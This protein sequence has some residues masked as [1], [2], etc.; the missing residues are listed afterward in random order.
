MANKNKNRKTSAAG[1]N[2][3]LVIQQLVV[4]APRR[5][6]YDV[7]DWR[8]ALQAA[9]NG[10][11]KQLYDLYDDIMI[12]AVLSDAVQKRI[13]A[14][15][16]SE[17]TFQ[18][19]GG[20]EVP[21]I[22]GLIDTTAWETLLAEIAKTRIFGRSGVEFCFA[23]GFSV[24]PIPPKHINLSRQEILI[25]DYDDSGIP[26]SGD[27]HILV[28]GKERDFGL[29]LKA[30]P[31]AIYKRGGFGDWSQWIELFGMPQ[32]VGKYNTYDP[33]SRKLL[34]E[35]FEKAGSAP[36][37][38]IP[39]EAEVETRDTNSG[40]G[41][42]YDEF[43]KANNEE[44]L[45]A[46]LGQTMTTVQGDK[47]AKS[48]GEVHKEVEEGKNRSDLRFVQRVLNQHVLPMLEARGYPVKGGR[49]VF[50]QA[51]E[52]LSV[53]DIVQL[54]GIMDIPQSYLHEKYSIPVPEEGEPVARR[55][56]SPDITF[57]TAGDADGPDR[58]IN[59]SDRGLFRRIRDFFVKAPLDGASLG[60]H[61]ML[62][63]DP[64]SMDDRLINS[65]ASGSSATFSPELFDYIS[66]DLLNAVRSAFRRSMRHADTSYAY[67]LR[68]DAFIT[69]LEMNL[70]HFSAAKTLAEVQALNT[71]FRESSSYADF[72][73]RA[74]EICS[75]F[76][77]A[78][79]RTE[80]ETAVLTAESASNYHRLKSKTR[81]FP[82]WKYVTAGDDR[83]RE[84]HALLDGVILAA[85]DPR[86][87]RIFPPNGWKCRCRVTPLMR[88]EAEGVNLK[89]MQRRVDEY[90]GTAEWE[91][92]RAQGWDSN[93]G[94]SAEIFN[95]NQQYI[96]KFPEKAAKYLG[97]LYYND[98]G[99]DSIGK[100][101]AAATTP[102]PVYAGDPGA[103]FASNN[104]FE[105]YMGRKL[106]LKEKVFKFHTTGSHSHRV[107]LLGCIREVLKDPDEVW[108]NNYGKDGSFNNLNFIKFYDGKVMNVI[109]DVKDGSVY[110]ITTWFEIELNARIKNPSRSSRRIDPRW[111]Y[112]RGL[113]LK[114]S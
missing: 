74:R 9:D 4:K 52:Q 54:S 39:N 51:V 20:G 75:T 48:L 15:T 69:A 81:L 28:L 29:L 62:L 13:D 40:S 17:L 108:L 88:H 30:A 94:E 26:Y 68:D 86:W 10:R 96:R 3:P 59:N 27:D 60:N 1:N 38:I 73:K 103:W 102:F 85:N 64:S 111:R 41:T 99:L 84:E 66:G 105:D 79:Q 71:A 5:R 12:D 97:S 45:I 22:A 50:P 101:A 37:V 82:Y 44:I 114:K 11:V 61:P 47:G 106:I 25:E 76:N 104:V 57:S 14:V 100:K 112:R 23:D 77:R 36:Y 55:A 58:E 24:E 65:V 33:A 98:Y 70:F 107:P 46:I 87:G 35:A 93:R 92:N 95:K 6:T 16:N 32:R 8:A 19:A 53:P 80:Y 83:V 31:Y 43:R 109:C 21:E 49:F 89:D 72:E 2:E 91:N 7:G 63:S 56:I 110:Q 18:D 78:W 90:F 34:E 113:L 67:G 42:S